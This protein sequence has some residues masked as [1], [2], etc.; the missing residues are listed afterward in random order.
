MQYIFFSVSF[1]FEIFFLSLSKNDQVISFIL[2]TI[3]IYYYEKK[4]KL[5]IV[6]NYRLYTII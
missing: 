4:K 6:N 3:Y 5:R 2:Y 1:N